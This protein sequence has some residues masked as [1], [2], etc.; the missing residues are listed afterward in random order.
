MLLIAEFYKIQGIPI[1]SR[2]SFDCKLV[3][4]DIVFIVKSSRHPL[5]TFFMLP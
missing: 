3:Q 1:L 4:I 2:N 5:T